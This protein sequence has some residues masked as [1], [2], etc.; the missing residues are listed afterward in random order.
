MQI[1]T[2]FSHFLC[3][4]RGA[5]VHEVE[6]NFRKGHCTQNPTTNSWFWSPAWKV[7]KLETDILTHFIPFMCL[8]HRFDQPCFV[9]SF[10][11]KTRLE[12]VWQQSRWQPHF[13]AS[14][15]CCAL[16]FSNMS[17]WLDMFSSFWANTMGWF[18]PLLC[19]HSPR[20]AFTSQKQEVRWW[21]ETWVQSNY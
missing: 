5:A 1:L 11:S 13:I 21:W 6:Q 7:V 9:A 17:L 19:Q 2:N 12:S 18:W 16:N 4:W 20:E 15:I 3:D 14:A 10:S 8:L